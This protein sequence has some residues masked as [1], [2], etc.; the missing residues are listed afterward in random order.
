MEFK[1]QPATAADAPRLTEIYFSA[2]SD[3]F[4]LRL[5]PPTDDV[6]TFMTQSFKSDVEKA[7]SD[8]ATSLMKIVGTGSDHE[9]APAIAGFA[10]WTFKEGDGDE[11]EEVQW[12]PSSDSELCSS[13]FALIDKE[14]KRAI[15][16][17]EHYCLDMLVIDPEF[18]RQGLGA[19]LLKW[20]LDRADE[21]RVVTFISSSPAARALYEK[22]GCRVLNKYEVIPDHW[23]STMVR[24]VRG[25][26]RG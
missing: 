6:R 10:L 2:F 16:D 1:I 26:R 4:S 12:P 3:N 20:G 15:G 22:H 5:L 21:K 23:Q 11:P 25:M 8:T 13:F 14:R 24:P 9:A 18:G 7:Q 17:Q 19:Q